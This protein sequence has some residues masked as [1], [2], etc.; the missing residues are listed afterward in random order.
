MRRDLSGSM[1]SGAVVL[2]W[3]ILTYQNNDKKP[4]PG[5]AKLF[6]LN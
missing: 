4:T 6:R 3:Q 2:A 1:A 5:A